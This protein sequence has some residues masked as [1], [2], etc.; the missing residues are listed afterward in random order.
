[1]PDDGVIWFDL[2][3]LWP[4][5]REIFSFSVKNFSFH[6]QLSNELTDNSVINVI[7]HSVCTY[8]IILIRAFLLV[9]EMPMSGWM[10]FCLTELD[11]LRSNS[12]AMRALGLSSLLSY[13]FTLYYL[14]LE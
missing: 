10:I 6:R 4:R 8:N 7:T 11:F 5:G 9:I 13:S 14:A 2:T 3:G 1:M 12:E